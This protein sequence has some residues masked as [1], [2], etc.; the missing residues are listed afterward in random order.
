MGCVAI[1]ADQVGITLYSSKSPLINNLSDKQKDK[2]S[3]LIEVDDM[4]TLAV[5]MD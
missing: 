3:D 5:A 4:L 2:L 1:E